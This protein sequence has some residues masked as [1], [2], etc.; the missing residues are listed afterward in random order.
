[1]FEIF[2]FVG[3]FNLL[4]RVTKLAVAKYEY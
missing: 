1:G 4:R 2:S 3:L